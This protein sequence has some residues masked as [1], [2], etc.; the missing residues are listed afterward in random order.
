MGSVLIV[1]PLGRRPY[2]EIHALQQELLRDRIAEK[3]P[4]TL[5]L[6]EHDEVVTLGRGTPDG[7]AD[8]VSVPVVPVERGGEATYHGP[9][10]MVAYPIR[11][12]PEGQRDLHAYLRQL[13]QVMIDVLAEHGVEGRREPGKTGVWIESKK[14][15]SIGVA[16]RR[17]VT[18]HGVALNG[19]TALEAFRDF[20]PCG[21]SSEVMT[22]LADHSTRPCDPEALGEQ[23]RSHF[24]KRFGYS[25]VEIRSDQG[26]D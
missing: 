8:A 7:A 15:A 26:S 17:W 25:M 19:T 6:V 12:L 13:E 20:Q 23:F 16:V 5:L 10:Q 14:V 24:A 18:W 22:R 11:Y 4:D 9:G 2:G 21:L 3:I 1:C